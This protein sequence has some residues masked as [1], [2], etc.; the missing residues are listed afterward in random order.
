MNTPDLVFSAFK[1]AFG[2]PA[3]ALKAPGRANIIGEH[4]D[5]N[6]GYVLPF[7]IDQ[8]IYFYAK[9]STNSISKIHALDVDDAFQFKQLKEI[10]LFPP[11]FEYLKNA[12]TLLQIDK[13]FEM[14]FGGNLPLGA[15]MSSSSAL[16]TGFISILNELFS[17]N[18]SSEEL[19]QYASM[20]ENGTG[21][22][23]GKMD[24]TSILLGEKDHVLLIDCYL[25]EVEKIPLNL[26]ESKFVLFDS[27]VQHKL[28]ETAYNQR[29]NTCRELLQI[30]HKHLGKNSFRGLNINE[31]ESIRDLL[32]HNQ[33]SCG[34]YVLE[35]NQ[36]VLKTVQLIRESNENF[37]DILFDG[38]DG[39]SQLYNVSCPELDLLVSLA[40][41]HSGIKGARLMGGGFG[42]C[43]IN[44]IKKDADYS[45]LIRQFKK[46]YTGFKEYEISPSQGIHLF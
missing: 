26:K 8:G 29:R 18:L 21:I 15:G 42:G 45:D 30:S 5:Y 43:T 41:G 35:E 12:L 32:T 31:L 13:P 34:K 44:L 33:W 22:E 24:Q 36:R 17:L 6:D 40:K 28:A 3:L 23:G 14:C 20:A 39:L 7:A 25:Q 38:H 16:T 9:S 19:I 37:G 27:G 2:Y 10:E 11:W 46:Q 1:D 4:T